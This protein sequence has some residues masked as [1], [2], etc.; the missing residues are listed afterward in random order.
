MAYY[1][2]GLKDLI[3]TTELN[4]EFF[5]SLN[6]FQI[7]FIEMCFKKNNDEQIGMMTQVEEINLNVFKQYKVSKF[8]RDF[9]LDDDI[10]AKAS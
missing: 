7:H 4:L 9:G 1:A 6:D 3:K 5:E 10:W 8:E 2:K